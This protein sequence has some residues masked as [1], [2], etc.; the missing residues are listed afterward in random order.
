MTTVYDS[1]SD[2]YDLWTENAPGAEESFAFYMSEYVKAR[3]PIV[4]L[5][6]G[7]GRIAVEAARRGCDVT[8]V[9]SS[10]GMLDVCRRKAES[11]GVRLT[12]VHADMREFVAP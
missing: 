1:L 6:V 9:D 12:L 8:G 4:E 5:G 3:G 2:I 11:A 7:T 10:A